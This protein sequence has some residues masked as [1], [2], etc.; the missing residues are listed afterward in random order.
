M[1]MPYTMW[2]YTAFRPSRQFSLFFI[3][4]ECPLISISSWYLL[5]HN[6]D[7]RGRR[8]PNKLIKG[9]SREDKCGPPTWGFRHSS[10]CTI[11]NLDLDGAAWNTTT[12]GICTYATHH[13]LPPTGRPI[14][15]YPFSGRREK[16]V[17]WKNRRIVAVTFGWKIRCTVAGSRAKVSEGEGN[18]DGEE[19][20]R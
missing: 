10:G 8:G 19:T 7:G 2:M 14:V 12:R 6:V 11:N 18:V 13:V 15:P 1:W 20:Q 17:C 4:C 9:S 16:A 3:Q 5:E